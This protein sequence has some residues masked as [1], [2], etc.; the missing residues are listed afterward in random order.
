MFAF[1]KYKKIPKFTKNRVHK[2][3]G[4]VVVED[5]FAANSLI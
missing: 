3:F 2:I 4:Y 5:L 1:G